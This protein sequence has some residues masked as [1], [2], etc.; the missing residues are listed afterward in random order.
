MYN[1]NPKA[2]AKIKQSY[3]EWE[4]KGKMES[5]KN[6]LNPKEGG[7]RERGIRIAGISRKHIEKWQT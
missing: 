3:K 6:L 1:I 7:K 5:F 4:N 2:N